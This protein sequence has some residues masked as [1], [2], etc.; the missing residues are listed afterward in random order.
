M[1][2]NRNTQLYNF[3]VQNSVKK[4]E[5]YTHTSIFNP[6][7][8]FNV[9]KENED[10]FYKVY[11]NALREGQL[12]T[13]TEVP[14]KIV[15]LIIDLD[16]RFNYTQNE[17]SYHPERYYTIEM[18]EELIRSYHSIIRDV[19]SNA[20]KTH[21][22]CIILEK[23]NPRLENGIVKDGIHIHFPY[24]YTEKW[25][26]QKI[27]RPRILQEINRKH[28]FRD[29]PLIN[30]LDD[31]VDSAVPSNNWFM[32]GSSKNIKSGVYKIT[33]MWNWKFSEISIE[34]M[35]DKYPE[36][37]NGASISK[38]L[39]IRLQFSPL[40][41]NEEFQTMQVSKSETNSSVRP[42]L[43]KPYNE[44][45]EDIEEARQLIELLPDECSDNYD[46]WIT[47]GYYIF[48]ISQSIQQ[49]FQLWNDFSMKSSKY[50]PNECETKWKTMELRGITIRDLENYI[51]RLSPTHYEEYKEKQNDYFIMECLSGSDNA[52]ARLIYHLYGQEFV[53]ADTEKKIW[54]QFK[55][56]R[57]SRTQ[58]GIDLKR[59][60]SGDLACRINKVIQKL[61]SQ[62]NE[63]NV[64]NQN[65]MENLMTDNPPHAEQIKQLSGQISALYKLSNNLGKYT[66]KKKILLECEEFFYDEHFF[67][68]LDE[69]KYLTV[70]NNGVYDSK[71]CN[72]R[73]GR[74]SD[75]CSK[76]TG[77]NYIGKLDKNDE[78]LKELIEIFSKTFVNP[79]LFNFFKQTASD[80]ILGGN[81][82]KI[83]VIWNGDGDNG[84][85]FI[86]ELLEKV[87]GDYFAT[88]PT[89]LITG[90]Q[91]SSSNATPEYMQFKGA[92]I[93]AV[94]ETGNDDNLNCGTMKKLTGGDSFYARGLFR[95]PVKINP[96][97]K[98]ILHCN[99]LPRVSAEDKAS[100][101]RIRV[102]PFEST[103]VSPNSKKLPESYSQQRKKKIF[104][105][106]N[107]LRDKMEQLTEVFASWLIQLYEEYGD[108]PLYE[109]EEVKLA[110]TH[111]HKD[112]DFYLQFMNDCILYTG[113][114]GDRMTQTEIFGT[115]KIWY[116][117]NFPQRLC[118]SR[119]Q[120]M[121]SI[122]KRIQKEHDIEGNGENGIWYNYLVVM[123]KQLDLIDDN[124]SVIDENISP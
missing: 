83:F 95:D 11:D 114:K 90:K 67:K 121:E 36:E 14:P 13:V 35:F 86:A 59:K 38:K 124:E 69:N 20:K 34:K 96:Q 115:F 104:P 31:V 85:S 26:Q 61:N 24:V 107:T 113:K 18:I 50:K 48:N 2:T 99:K 5:E 25:V 39:S 93:V 43:S 111:Y 116:K 46:T 97:F 92:R 68:K 91:N 79:K 112:N 21:L 41:L 49:G 60:L 10:K 16:F 118:P 58:Q 62:I 19:F 105:K 122:S 110:T 120:V 57:W 7:R 81:R 87:F 106:D 103:F 80:F 12:P 109:P 63:F 42:I 117:E 1:D 76:T 52:I 15:P 77:I 94:S 28:I 66:Y 88:A 102:L 37:L 108:D 40:Q 53:C 73:D 98:V 84:K 3:I 119:P 29:L 27:I 45:V 72:F 22:R 23:D 101:N 51:Q 9:K 74:P 44:L 65:Y 33:H 17:L 71:E 75:Y 47:L 54:Y 56:H 78:R 30:K 4:G 64:M 89:S 123:D 55:E 70:F 6:S 100:W 32:Y 8:R 82:H